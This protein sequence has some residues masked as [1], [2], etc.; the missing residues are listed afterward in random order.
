MASSVQKKLSSGKK[1]PA[2]RNASP[3]AYGWCFQ[4]GAGISLV[5]DY[6]RDFTHLKMEGKS[7]DIELSFGEGKKLYAQAKSVTQIGDQSNAGK[8]FSNAL[9]VLSADE[10]NGDAVKLVYITNIINPLSS[11]MTSA[12]QFGLNYDFSILPKDDQKKVIVKGGK[13]FPVDKFQLQILH[14]FGEGKDRFQ[15]IKEKINEFLRA[16]IGDAS[17][18]SLLL[19]SWFT[20]FMIN[21]SDKPDNVKSLN[22]PKKDIIYPLIAILID[23][24]I[25]ELE[26]SKVCDYEDY[27]EVEQEFRKTIYETTCDYEFIAQVLGDFIDKR[28]TS[29]DKANYKYEFIKNDWRNYENDFTNITNDEKR[30]ALVKILLLTIITRNNIINDIKTAVNL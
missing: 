3:S 27:A 5:L 22:L 21:A 26:F 7:D 10:L 24:P 13:N 6:V 15:K 14:F 16:S 29:N 17:L 23:P 20:T 19:D 1:K 18:S 25:S 12:Y 28:K 9:K 4:V 30:Q 11:K 2:N 8:N